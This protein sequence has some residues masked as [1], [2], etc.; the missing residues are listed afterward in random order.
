[1]PRTIVDLPTDYFNRGAWPP[2]RQPSCAHL[3]SRPAVVLAIKP[4]KAHPSW[5][6]FRLLLLPPA[7]DRP[8]NLLVL[9]SHL[10]EAVLRKRSA[11]AR[12]HFADFSSPGFSGLSSVDIGC[13]LEEV[14]Q[15]LARRVGM[16]LPG[17]VLEGTQSRA[18]V[19]LHQLMPLKLHLEAPFGF[20]HLMRHAGCVRLSSSAAAV[21]LPRSTTSTKALS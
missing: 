1:M 21:K 8:C 2:T 6:L 13:P 15:E 11:L 12:C 14:A 9:L 17:D 3:D 16:T 10:G 4:Q 19:S 20:V 7:L 18:S 5:A